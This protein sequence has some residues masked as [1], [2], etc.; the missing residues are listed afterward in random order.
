MIEMWMAVVASAV[1]AIFAGALAAAF[2][3]RTAKEVNET[4]E[5]K[6]IVD[7]FNSILTQL[8][9]V[10]DSFRKDVERLR[11]EMAEDRSR[12][13]QE[14]D[15]LRGQVRTLSDQLHEVKVAARMLADEL[16]KLVSAWPVG[17]EMPPLSVEWRKYL[18]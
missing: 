10:N 14:N 15:E 16:G 18:H 7:A 2:A 5:D 11:D 13:Q 3:R 4:A 17:L 12:Y 8:L 6:Q 1:S 9:S